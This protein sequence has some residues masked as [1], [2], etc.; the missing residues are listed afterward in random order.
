MKALIAVLVLLGLLWLGLLAFG[1]RDRPEGD[2]ADTAW[3]EGL[4]SLFPGPPPL[5]AAALG[6]P[7]LE[8]QALVLPAQGARCALRVRAARITVR[9]ARLRLIQGT[10]VTLRFVPAGD[11]TLIPSSLVFGLGETKDLTVTETGG[12]LEV[13]C[14]AAGSHGCRLNLL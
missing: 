6:G 9:R 1:L 7:C 5:R 13:A 8:G 2:T 3:T 11:S 4:Q 12:A 10:R 14:L